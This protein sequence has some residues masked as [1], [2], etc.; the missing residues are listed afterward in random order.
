MDSLNFKFNVVDIKGDNEMNNL[1][2]SNMNKYSNLNSNETFDLKINTNYIKEDLIKNKKGE[3]TT[4]LI[5]KEISFQ[6]SNNEI[7][8]SFEFTEQ[9]KTKNNSDK[10]EFKKYEKSIKNNFVNSKINELILKLSSLK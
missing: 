6:V 4:F 5:K 10:F 8:K 2:I 7:N 3:V 1:V 9:L